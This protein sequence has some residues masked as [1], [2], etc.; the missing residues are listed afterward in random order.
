M[1]VKYIFIIISLFALPF[2]ISHCGSNENFVTPNVLDKHLK[3]S[4]YKYKIA[5]IDY[6]LPEK[7]LYQL[8]YQL[9]NEKF[10][11][12]SAE[13]I[14]RY[15]SAKYPNNDL[16]S[17]YE[18]RSSFFIGDFNYFPGIRD[19]YDL[20]LEY[21]YRALKIKPDDLQYI[22][23]RSYA[24]GRVGLFVRKL[25]GGLS[26]I[27]DLQESRQLIDNIIG[28]PE[29]GS[30]SMDKIDAIINKGF[31]YTEALLTRGEIYKDSPGFFGGDKQIAY[32]IFK[33]VAEKDP[34]NMRAQILMANHYKN[35]NIYDKAIEKYKKASKIF[36]SDKRKPIPEY[37]LMYAY[38]PRNLGDIY[39]HQKKYDKSFE[40]FKIH[41]K[42][43]PTS[44]TGYHM[45]AELYN[46]YGDK[47]KA[48]GFLEKALYYDIKNDGAQ[49]LL[50]RL[51]NK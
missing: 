28:N 14:F 31:Y 23:A 19:P 26:G 3:N 15:L 33:R 25:K 1:K 13:R 2:L 39:W 30:E 42:R 38:I 8:G 4:K 29:I 34:N 40:S 17:Y 43:M 47:E 41:I 35:N 6:S 21:I 9:L 18:S 24:I 49:R 10:D 32:K 12:L 20:S 5:K 11:P 36:E 44:A 46:H 37:Y 45:L 51:K 27:N 7:E 22:L 50:K 48:L 16:Y